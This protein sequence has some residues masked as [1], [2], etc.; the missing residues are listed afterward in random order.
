[1]R[2]DEWIPDMR[3]M[4]RGGLGLML[5]NIADA[6][7]TPTYIVVAR[8]IPKVF[9]LGPTDALRAIGEFRNVRIARLDALPRELQPGTSSPVELT[10]EQR[11]VA[12]RQARERKA[13]RAWSHRLHE[14]RPK[15]ARRGHKQAGRPPYGYQWGRRIRTTRKAG[16]VERRREPMQIHEEQ[17][18]TVRLIFSTYLEL[19]NFSLTAQRLNDREIKSPTGGQWSRAGVRWILANSTYVGRV[20]YCGKEFPGVHAPIISDQEFLAVKKVMQ[21]TAKPRRLVTS[22]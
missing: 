12:V 5:A 21:E 19:R 13:A 16:V 15:A 9:M 2:T 1:M 4:S 20:V 7:N 3:C 8:E 18:R 14:G 6:P 11:R 10:A 17:A 22:R